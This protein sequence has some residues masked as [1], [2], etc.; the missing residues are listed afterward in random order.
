MCRGMIPG[1]IW[2][3]P[4]Y[5][6]FI[7]YLTM[8]EINTVVSNHFHY[9]KFLLFSSARSRDFDGMLNTGLPVSMYTIKTP[10]DMCRFNRYQLNYL[11]IF[12]KRQISIKLF[13]LYQRFQCRDNFVFKVKFVFFLYLLLSASWK[14]TICLYIFLISDR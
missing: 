6:L 1:P 8:T 14:K 2:E 13:Y 12:C 9:V 11:N 4:C 5:N 3:R 7:T 10:I